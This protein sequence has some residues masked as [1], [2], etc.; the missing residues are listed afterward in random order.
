MTIRRLLIAAL[1]CLLTLSTF[2][3]TNGKCGNNATWELDLRTGVITISGYGPMTNYFSSQNKKSPIKGNKKVT[4]AII[5]E[6]ITSIGANFFEECENLSS[7]QI[8][9]TV[10]SI[11]FGAFYHCTSLTS[12]ELPVSVKEIGAYAFRACYNLKDI[13]LPPLVKGIQDKTFND[14]L[15]AKLTAS[16]AS[17]KSGSSNNSSK[18]SY[19]TINDV[20][21]TADGKTL[22]KYPAN[23]PALSYIVPDGVEVIGDNAFDGVRVTEIR[24][25][26][27]LKKIG[28]R[29]FANNPEIKN[30]KF[31]ASL[32]TIEDY[33]FANCTKM[34]EFTFPAYAEYIGPNILDGCT[35]LYKIYSPLGV[36][37]SL[38]GIKIPTNVKERLSYR[39]DSPRPSSTPQSTPATSPK[40]LPLLTMVEDSWELVDPT[41]N[42]RIDANETCRIR[43]SILNNGKGPATNCEARVTM[44]GTTNGI[45]AKNVKIPTI[46]VGQMRTIEIPVTSN[47]QTAEGR[48]TLSIEVYEPN[49]MGVP[50]FDIAV[51]TKAYLKPNIQVVD[52]QLASESG[53]FQKQR[54]ITLAFVVQNI[55]EGDAENVRVN[56]NLP[57][58]VTVWEGDDSYTFASLQSGESKKVQLSIM[59]TG[60]YAASEIPITI[61]VREKYG[62]FAQNKTVEVALNKAASSTITIEAKDEPKRERQ[63]IQLATIGSAVDKNIP[64]SK[65]Q[66][67]Q[68]FVVIIANENY[69]KVAGVP[70]AINDGNI[71]RQYCEKTLGIPSQNIH[72]QPDATLNE[73]QD[74]V[75]WLRDLTA[76]YKGNARII[77]YYAG[78]G[79]PDETSKSAYL[80]PVD[81]NGSNAA[82]GY[83]LDDLY[84]ALAANPTKSVTVF[85][86]ACF[87]GSK[88]EGGMIASARGV[89]LKAKAGIPQ[90][91]MVV[92]SA[93]TGDETAYPNNKEGHGM[94]TYFL[95]KKLQ[96][97]EGNVTYSELSKYL[98]ENVSQ[99]SIVLNSKSQTPTVIPSSAIG[100]EWQNWRLK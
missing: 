27:T 76:A 90:G 78:H 97:T 1:C 68:T 59:A 35:H 21:F 100:A 61:D 29:A 88:R 91:N 2:G 45:S 32:T 19:K 96:E 51:N 64:V 34:Y 73:I 67:K 82:T 52:Y 81:G 43:F 24:L 40:S 83:K 80:L 13:S 47:L 53:K 71:F 49:G 99:Q 42:N 66:N 14:E 41:N 54:A 85:L 56:I 70:Y 58:N 4:K 5:R 18:P 63:E 89:A 25:P 94:F 50:S 23:K 62:T 65:Q 20:V 44:R 30:I 84:A 72:Y 22:V 38:A 86:D 77:F 6:G 69:R 11:G 33:A 15:Q 8:P 75:K 17:N 46:N 55:G 60:N 28:K 3:A 39:P 10:T 98:L 57:T 74:E 79:I 7:V 9:N 16:L 95:L 48:V 12:V 93:A 92:F 87:S 37:F 26:N 31:P 36:G